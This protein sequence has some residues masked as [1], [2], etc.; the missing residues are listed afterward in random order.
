M[1]RATRRRVPALLLAV[2]LVHGCAPSYYDAYLAQHPGWTPDLPRR[3]MG[4]EEIVASLQAPLERHRTLSQ[5]KRIRLLELGT[6]PWTDVPLAALEDGS[7]R[8]DPA[9]TV[10]VVAE[11]QCFW[12]NR[13]HQAY[14]DA[15]SWYV[16]RQGGLVAWRHTTFGEGCE[17][18]PQIEG[19]VHSVPG[20]EETLRKLVAEPEP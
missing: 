5:V 12:S 4:A 6:T 17:A 2:A 11:L 16:V 9:R 13:T 1:T 7:W 3:G 8:P 15:F 20:F 14:R 10:V 18:D 19:S